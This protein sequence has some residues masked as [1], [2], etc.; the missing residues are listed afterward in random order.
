MAIST[1]TLRNLGK[2]TAYA[3]LDVLKELTPNTTELARGVRY[4]A[5]SVRDFV[6]SNTSRLQTME[7]QVD[8]TKAVRK[9]KDFLTD[10]WNDIKQGNL[11]LGDLSDQSLEDWDQYLDSF[12][13]GGDVI[14]YSDQTVEDT[15][16]T[17]ASNNQRIGGTSAPQLVSTDARVLEGL[18]NVNNSLG[19]VTLKAA[20]YQTTAITN[21]ILT[22][23]ALQDQ[24][25]HTIEKQLDSIN[26]N[27][28]QLVKFQGENQSAINSAQLAFF[29][30]MSRYIKKQEDRV[31]RMNTR[32]SGR[33]YRSKASQFLSDSFFDVEGYK[34]IVKENFEG[35]QFGMLASMMGMLDPSMLGMLLGGGM[36]GKLQP[37]KFALKQLLKAAIPRRAKRA[38]GQGD[39]QINTM[40][41]TMLTRLGNMQYDMENHPIL[42]L[43]GSLF[44]VDSRT[45][46]TLK[47][48]QYKRDAMSWNGEAQKALVQVIP[49]ELA[50]IKAALTGKDARYFDAQTG[51]FM[52]RRDIQRRTQRRLQD[53]TEIPFANIFNKLS[54]APEDLRDKAL[55]GN[56]QAEVQD[57]ISKIVNQAVMGDGGFTQSLAN[58]LDEALAKGI[59]A[60][61]GDKTDQRRM[62]TQLARAI[63]DARSNMEGIL[64]E[65]QEQNSA[66]AQIADEMANAYGNVSFED[67]QRFIGG[68]AVDMVSANGGRYSYTGK[69]LDE[70]GD[71]ERRRYEANLGAFSKLRNRI[72]NMPNSRNRF[73]RGAGWI[74]NRAIDYTAGGGNG[75]YAQATTNAANSVFNSIYDVA[76]LGRSPF[77]GQQAASSS[78]TRRNEASGAGPNAGFV[79]T[80]GVRVSKNDQATAPGGGQQP[81]SGGIVN[82]SYVESQ[83]RATGDTQQQMA[84][85][86]EEQN[87]T[88]KKAWDPEKGYMGKFFNSPIIKKLLEWFKK[89][90]AGQ[91]IIGGAKTAGNFIRDLFTKDSTDE[92][93]NVTRSVKGRFQDA[94]GN[95]K[96]YIMRQLGM[97]EDGTKPANDQSPET[98]IGA[99]KKTAEDISTAGD[100]ITGQ[101]SSDGKAPTAAERK[102]N[103]KKQAQGIFKAFTNVVQKKAP[104]LLTGAVVGA[105]AGL[106]MNGSTGLLGSLFLPGGPIGGAI[107]GAGL[108]Y[109]SSTEGFKKVIFGEKGEDGQRTGG[110]LNSAMGDKFKRLLPTLGI[111]AAAGAI[112]KVLTSGMGGPV[113]AAANAVGFFPSIFLPG[114]IMGASIMG[115]AAAYA[116]KNSKFMD[117]LFGAKDESGKRTGAFLSNAYNKLT[118]KVK[119]EGASKEDRGLISK[120]FS[121]IKGAAGG[122]ITATTLSQAGLLG[123][124]FGLGGPI[125]AA[126]AG[127]SL[128]I[129][130]VGKKFDEYLFGKKDEQGKRKKTGLFSR[131]GTYINMQIAQPVSHYLTSTAEQ[132]A[133]WAKEQ[134]EVPF[135]MAVGP[136]MDSIYDLKET[137]KNT[138]IETIKTGGKAL[139]EKID[140]KILRPIGGAFTN[141]ILKPLGGIAG[142]LIK[143]GL[144][145]GASIIGAPFQLLSLAMSGKRRKGAKLFGN[146][147]RENRD[148]NLQNWWASQEE[149]GKKPT[150]FSKATDRLL[151]TMATG[152]FGT[153][154]RNNEMIS[155]FTDAFGE[156]DEGKGRNNLNW[157]GAPADRKRYRRNRK[158]NEKDLRQ[159]NKISR[160]VNKLRRKDRSRED[161]DLSD[162]EVQ[163]R[164]SDIKRRFGVTLSD[165]DELRQ[166]TYHYDEWAK[167]KKKPGEKGAE[168][169]TGS[170]AQ[171]VDLGPETQ[172]ILQ[173]QADAQA[174]TSKT[175][176]KILDLLGRMATKLGIIADNSQAQTDIASGQGFDTED[177][178]RG[179]VAE[180][181]DSNAVESIQK[182]KAAVNAAALGKVLDARDKKKAR[183]AND[184]IVRGNTSGNAHDEEEVTP[185]SIADQ[186]MD[187]DGEA[188]AGEEKS[189]SGIGGIISGL[190]SGAGALLK[191]VFGSKAG[192]I[193]LLGGALAAVLT[194]P[195]LRTT[196]GNIL[197]DVGGWIVDKIKSVPDAVADL[198][199][200]GGGV[201]DQRVTGYD[202][203]G[204]PTGTVKNT[205]LA[206]N[207]LTVARK[208][209]SVLM[210]A[211]K[212]GK[213]IVNALGD[214][215]TAKVLSKIPGVKTITNAAKS[216]TKSAAS[217]VSKATRS[218]GK[219]ARVTQKAANAASNTTIVQKAFTLVK[220][221]LQKVGESKLGKKLSPVVSKVGTFLNDLLTKLSK[222]KIASKYASKLV[223]ALG[224]AGAKVASYAVPALNV[225]SL[226]VSAGE[227]LN[228]GL[229]PETIF[230]INP[231]GIDLKMNLVAGVIGAITS[232]SGM[233]AVVSVLNE[234]VT[235]YTGTDFIQGLAVTI[236]HV[237][238]DDADDIKIENAIA[239]FQKEVDNYNKANGTNLSVDAYNDMKNKGVVGNVVNSIANIFGMGD[240]TDYSQYEVTSEGNG[241]GSKGRTNNQKSVGY[242]FGL[243]SDPR[244]ANL[245]LG[246]F[247]N[248]QRSTMATGGCGPTALS[249]AANALGLGYSPADMAKVA[250]QGGYI[251]DGGANANLFGQGANAIGLQSSK[252]KGAAGIMN[253][254]AS[255]QPVILAGKSQGYGKNPY[256]SAGHIVT[257]TG[258]D[259]N[260]NV[261]VQDP[262]RGTSLYSVNDLAK[263]MTNGWS[264][265]RNR[266][267][268]YGLVDDAFGG[269]FGEIA[270][271]GANIAF[272]K[273]TGKSLDE[274]T[275]AIAPDATDSTEG[276]SSSGGNVQK[277][278]LSGNNAA[279]QIHSFLIGQQGGYT[280]KAAA[281][282][283]GCWQAESGLNPNVVEGYY[284]KGYPGHDRVL[285][286]NSSMNDFTKNVL[287]P[288]YARSGISI[289]KDAYK[290]TDGNYYPGVGLAQWTGPRGYNLFQYAKKAGQKWGDLAPQLGLFN[291]EMKERGLKD[292]INGASNAADAASIFLDGYEMY[293][294]FG[295]SNPSMLN[296][297][298]SYANQIYE[299]FGGNKKATDKAEG[300]GLLDSIMNPIMNSL[301][302]QVYGALGVPTSSTGTTE[303]GSFTGT[304]GGTN[305]Q[306]LDF[307]S[308]PNATEQQKQLVTTMNSI[309]GKI[310]YSLSGPQDPDQGSASCASTVAWAYNKVL[311]F[312]PGGAGMASST[313]QSKDDRF[314]TI[315]TNDGK[316]RVDLSKLQPGDIVYQ[317]WDQTVNTGKM[318]HT[319]M[320]AGNGQ[321]L[322]H[323]GNPEYGPV[324]KDLGDYRQKHTMMVRRYKGFIN[325]GEDTSESIG[326][327]PGCDFSINA[328]GQRG[329]TAIGYG[330]GGSAAV[331]TNNRGVETRLDS[332]I[333]YLAQI[334][335]NTGSQGNGPGT[336]S[337]GGSTTVNVD[338]SKKVSPTIVVSQPPQRKYLG[339]DDAAHEYLRTQHRRIAAVNHP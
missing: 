323:G 226:V 68:T 26:K 106:L 207:L 155:S 86:I 231:D 107:L 171:K 271:A 307:S 74:I 62:A 174:E 287:F 129:L 142:S 172:T 299:Q 168:A 77:Q 202:E 121:G 267:Q 189:S 296:E 136:I 30:Q 204:N 175:S 143:T 193:A 214:T 150:A 185:Q 281:G 319:E 195:E 221:A 128:G 322:S 117:I 43:L 315:Y 318:Q 103:A 36:G 163:S 101:D 38:I 88:T 277:I 293:P 324:F 94:F 19:K 73:A 294:G 269:L 162:E 253:S 51:T 91:R 295:A 222:V 310:K 173:Q 170:S 217:A 71:E 268:G 10:A 119:A 212:S 304:S 147:L 275:S 312:K 22:Q 126:I 186:M 3:S 284:L 219:A 232:F 274:F 240:K 264:M 338:N 209:G 105:G 132:F 113:G 166:F 321:D 96:G 223:A 24:H 288:A 57:Q 37:Q 178:D 191:G 11:A 306:T 60:Q 176:N 305:G 336:A 249:S 4:G 279:T 333:Q 40:I 241:V 64:K 203:E 286:S 49:K 263:N 135:R 254:L 262:M 177:I 79:S 199:G 190:T 200:F 329:R 211:A 95:A 194:N 47:L 58:A 70:M 65:L 89:S 161:A 220:E 298:K 16:T 300:Y 141:F 9:A 1:Q 208:D 93:G 61:G 100:V 87:E 247:P 157:L 313:S 115:A 53:A 311:G 139:Y 66:F 42:G 72:R 130:G 7:S 237:I 8:R 289:N 116:V 332:V 266:A 258:L 122:V 187:E 21:S 270:N 192:L 137:V 114:G 52:S 301:T 131:L 102:E 283:M 32:T 256:T 18:K 99:V 236:Y 198:L 314:Q 184:A 82:Q 85:N 337:T 215:S 23:T 148:E 29:D 120:I 244:W 250:V 149:D 160:Y 309:N 285:A 325:G 239:N 183:A 127:A 181:I 278:Q 196:V 13:T 243:Q 14:S 146:F 169:T 205:N 229:S 69:R 125:G 252:V 5:D 290:G 273:M 225:I 81:A 180:T 255:G 134:I 188:A 246:K 151:Y 210:D 233:G 224:K 124:V 280:S 156:T 138:T 48:S 339:Q 272:K 83:K 56:M 235:E 179:D 261:V 335:Q 28:V 259:R 164:I 334:A 330:P 316:N 265:K 218:A 238:A 67:L 76:M 6:R 140:E 251:S 50:E 75:R 308:S 230:K 245:P 2:S 201:N 59:G 154:F 112:L 257:A 98:V 45:N 326:N 34:N 159:W 145:A 327:G 78:A 276:S 292:K 39:S 165:A 20:Q 97:N 197:G 133:W 228:A 123:S 182:E 44:G 55:W 216:A 302:S 291:Q 63:N 80:G 260:G 320:Y 25:F 227:T 41:K 206:A 108:S 248:G 303:D 84:D 234:I 92:E 297:R 109:L 110:I 46:R 111:G 144:F 33:S 27:L 152:P 31:A 35:S 213:G 158:Q 90:T 331:V 118:G 242:G 54:E 167:G 104:K 15:E 17:P 153:F 12:D 282:I 328:S 317:N